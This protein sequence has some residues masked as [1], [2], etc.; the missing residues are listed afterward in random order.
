MMESGVVFALL[1]ALAMGHAPSSPQE[2]SPEEAARTPALATVQ[3]SQT[4][5]KPK[6]IHASQKGKQATAVVNVTIVHQVIPE[7]QPQSV[8]LEVSN[9]YSTPPDATAR[10]KPAVQKVTISGKPGVVNAQVEV[11]R[12]S[13][14]AGFPTCTIVVE[15]SL[16]NPSSG[17]TILQPDPATNSQATL[18]ISEK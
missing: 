12:P 18:A 2:K 10:Y 11:S 6:D 7:D 3:I 9:Y 1:A 5:I 17:L 8:T 16:A 13:C 4:T 15:A 14:P